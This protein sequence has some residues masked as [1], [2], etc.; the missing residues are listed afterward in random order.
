MI[1][2]RCSLTVAA[3]R[4]RFV[5]STTPGRRDT[6]S[7]NGDWLR[8]VRCRGP[9]QRCPGGACPRFRMAV[10]ARPS[11][12]GQ[13]PSG[14]AGKSLEGSCVALGA[15]PL[16]DSTWRCRTSLPPLSATIQSDREVVLKHRRRMSRFFDADF[17]QM[18]SRRQ[19][20]SLQGPLPVMGGFQVCVMH[21]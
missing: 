3:S 6:E 10:A 14:H 20:P 17:E 1:G 5:R 16:F 2:R 15:S 21:M 12:R 13:A 8:D 7:E 19:S 4:R 11:K 18:F 9:L